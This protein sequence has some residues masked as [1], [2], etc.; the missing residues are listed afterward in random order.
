[1][2]RS[3]MR[4]KG[5]IRATEPVAPTPVRRRVVWLGICEALI[6]LAATG[7][8]RQVVGSGT[9][10]EDVMTVTG[11]AATVP[12]SLAALLSVP[13][14]EL[15]RVDVAVRNLLCAED[16]PGSEGIDVTRCLAK[17]DEWARRVRFETQRH[18]YRLT[19]PRYAGHYK[20]SEAVFRMEMLVQVLQE[21]CGV[22]YNPDRIREVDFTDSKDLFI[23]GLF[24]PRHGGTCVSLPVLYTA[25]ARRL[26]Y[27]VRLVRAK[28]HILCRWDG[29]R[30]RVNVEAAGEGFGTYDDAHY[31]VWPH[32]ISDAEVARGEYLKSLSPAEELAVFLAA[33]GHCLEDTGRLAE[34]REAYVRASRLAPHVKDYRGYLAT[35][36]SGKRFVPAPVRPASDRR[37]A[38]AARRPKSSPRHRPIRAQPWRDRPYGRHGLQFNAPPP[39]VPGAMPHSP[40]TPRP[41]YGGPNP[42]ASVPRPLAR[43]AY[44]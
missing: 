18:L 31:K 42:N 19:D 11:P 21:D 5:N 16:F 9:T 26:R 3:R 27:P 20:H 7:L 39:P 17:L 32:R 25:V 4:T 34:A 33:R 24:D 29:P 35:L 13:P 37:R 8:T 28:A 14:A 15:G 41:S 2:S 40:T 22:R 6:V 23:H 36:G 43:H 12:A 30:E 1:M 38:D 10:P 44:P